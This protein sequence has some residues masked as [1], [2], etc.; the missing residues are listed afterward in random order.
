MAME[1]PHMLRERL[2]MT[3]IREAAEECARARFAEPQRA[4]VDKFESII[5]R[6]VEA[7]TDRCATIAKECHVIDA[8]M[9]PE[10]ERIW[11]EAVDGVIDAISARSSDD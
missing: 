9:L 7:E 10:H 8:R 6:A 11:N 3:P 1:A 5:T 4:A 2:A